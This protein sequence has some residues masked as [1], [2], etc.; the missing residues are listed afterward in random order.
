YMA[1][2]QWDALNKTIGIYIIDE[3]SEAGNFS[4]ES[5]QTNVVTVDFS[6]TDETL[7]L[8]TVT[9]PGHFNG[10]VKLVFCENYVMSQNELDAYARRMMPTDSVLYD[11]D[12]DEP[13]EYI[14]TE[15]NSK[16]SRVRWN[17]SQKTNSFPAMYYDD[18]DDKFGSPITG[19]KKFRDKL[20]VFTDNQRAYLP[21]QGDE[22]SWKSVDS[23]IGDIDGRG[24]IAPRSL[25]ECSEG[26]G[27]LCQDGIFVVTDNGLKVANEIK[28]LLVNYSALEQ[29]CALMN[30][31]AKTGQLFVSLG[32]EITPEPESGLDNGIL[33]ILE[34]ENGEPPTSLSINNICIKIYDV[35]TV[36]FI[37]VPYGIASEGVFRKIYR[38]LTGSGAF[39][40]IRDVTEDISGLGADYYKETC[41][42]MEMSKDGTRLFVGATMNCEMEITKYVLCIYSI[43]NTLGV[44]QTI[45]LFGTPIEVISLHTQ[46]SN[47]TI[48][49][50]VDS[51]DNVYYCIVTYED[52]VRNIYVFKYDKDGNYIRSVLIDTGVTHVA[53]MIIYEDYIYIFQA[54]YGM[55]VINTDLEELG[56]VGTFFSS[57]VT[58]SLCVDENGVVHALWVNYAGDA[59]YG[60]FYYDDVNLILNYNFICNV[61]NL[62]SVPSGYEHNVAISHRLINGISKVQLFYS[63]STP[64][65]LQTHIKYKVYTGETLSPEW[66][67]GLSPVCNYIFRLGTYRYPLPNLVN[68][69]YHCLLFQGSTGMDFLDYG[70]YNFGI[71]SVEPLIPSLPETHSELFDSLKVGMVNYNKCYVLQLDR[72]LRTGEELWCEYDLTPELMLSLPFQ[73]NDLYYFDYN[74]NKLIRCFENLDADIYNDIIEN[75][76]PVSSILETLAF[77]Y[78][79]YTAQGFLSRFKI[80]GAFALNKFLSAEVYVDGISLISFLNIIQTKREFTLPLN[81][82]ELLSFKFSHGINEMLE[83]INFE[84]LVNQIKEKH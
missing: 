22:G 47:I 52:P 10:N 25:F 67:V 26:V 82:G 65:S 24:L 5:D 33:E 28:N 36:T 60:T 13:E 9:L 30:Y 62:G 14:P 63:E 46:Y 3:D 6:G 42:P 73:Y 45:E 64:T 4:F 77:D 2:I 23:L 61:V 7:Q 8:S 55:V 56:F 70:F 78:W 21:L 53:K 48:D 18:I 76:I 29:R 44:T 49:L 17:K 38:R 41:C 80:D 81:R 43:V 1:A 84:H 12:E 20:F 71:L 32:D 72:F 69:G 39:E 27:G 37:S 79:E 57:T 74:H 83:L 75:N 51:L 50:V 66:L 54:G 31:Y 58:A 40:L 59:Q 34:V 15:V 68:D 11:S 35:D 16:V 19:I